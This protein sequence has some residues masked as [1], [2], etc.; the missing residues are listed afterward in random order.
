MTVVKDCQ[1]CPVCN[2][3]GLVDNGFYTQTSG[4]WASTNAAPEKC[5]SCDGKGIVWS[6][7]QN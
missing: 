1:R 7:E 3:N 6:D 4:T 5:R 2:G